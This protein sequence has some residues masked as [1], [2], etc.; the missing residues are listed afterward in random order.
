MEFLGCGAILQILFINYVFLKNLFKIDFYMIQ[1]IQS[2]YLLI[3]SLISISSY[4]IFPK[5]NFTFNDLSFM[6]LFVI[7]YLCLGFFVSFFNIFLFK[8]R[9]LQLILNKIH[10]LIHL[11]ILVVFFYCFYIKKI[12]YSDFQWILTPILSTIFLLLAN[13]GIKS[14]EDL[15][16]SVDRLR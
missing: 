11:L 12:N 10:L 4:L 5:I 9:A 7:P 2:I 1:R 14:D 6:N 13:K 8:K 16:R 3:V 15:I